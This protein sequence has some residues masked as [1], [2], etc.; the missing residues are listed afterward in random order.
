MLLTEIRFPQSRGGKR[1]LLAC[2]L[3]FAGCAGHAVQTSPIPSGPP[4][5]VSEASI[6][7]PASPSTASSPEEGTPTEESVEEP[8]VI[9]GIVFAKTVFEGL[10]EASYVEL[11]IIDQSDP[12]KTYKL[13]IGEK[14][15]PTSFPWNF[16][17]VKPG[18]FFIDLPPGNYR[19]E[20]IAIPVGTGTTLAMEPMD[21]AFIVEESKAVYLGT[22]KVFGIKEK[23]R[24]GG[25][26]VLKPGFEYR[27]EVLNEQEEA[28]VIFRQRYAEGP[29]EM[30]VQL[31]Q[32]FMATN[33]S[34]SPNN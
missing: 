34:N 30:K 29:P 33:V 5:A 6:G 25:V 2:V 9:T 3:L 10:L 11:G 7:S 23:I 8:A 24:L 4:P 20:S 31:M 28:M 15:N 18:Y 12:A 22:L 26:P 13:R 19:I 27:A 16:Q 21:I 1:W 14:A 32:M 17:T